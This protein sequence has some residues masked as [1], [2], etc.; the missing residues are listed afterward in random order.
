MISW[1]LTDGG[2]FYLFEGHPVADVLGD[3]FELDGL[4]F[5]TGPR[6]YTESGFG[7]DRE[8]YRTQHT[9]GDVVTALASAGLR[10]EFV[11]EFPFAFWRRWDGMVRDDRGD[12]RCRIPPPSRSPSPFVRSTPYSPSGAESGAIDP[13]YQPYVIRDPCENEHREGFTPSRPA[14]T[15]ERR[16]LIDSTTTRRFRRLESGSRRP[17]AHRVIVVGRVQP[18]IVRN[19]V[20]HCEPPRDLHEFGREGRR[21]GINCMAKYET[22]ERRAVRAVVA[23]R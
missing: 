6:Q 10:I 1:L 5:E 7:V 2:I 17:R 9:L 22:P 15:G 11:H 13:Y 12:G 18:S 16:R 20:T 3:D 19:G 4:Y 23:C 21:H 14:V 8:H